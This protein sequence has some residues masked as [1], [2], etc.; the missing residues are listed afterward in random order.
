MK[1]NEF[2]SCEGYNPAEHM[3]PLEGGLY[4]STAER[5]RWFNTYRKENNLPGSID[6]GGYTVENTP[7]G[8]VW[9][10]EVSVTLGT[11]VYKGRFM[12]PVLNPNTGNLNEIALSTAYTKAIGRALAHAGFGNDE[13][14][15]ADGIDGDILADSP[16]KVTPAA[17][18][19]PVTVP[20][21]IP[22]PAPI[23]E[24]D[25]EGMTF[26]QAMAVVVSSRLNSS[27]GNLEGKTMGEVLAII[28]KCVDYIA[29]H[30]EKY[31]NMPQVVEAAKVLT[32]MTQ[33]A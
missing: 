15:L 23:P 13:I 4:L 14:D 21:P 29:K 26:E 12:K 9:I 7:A 33:A 28:P 17:Q 20:K 3:L 1:N 11:E 25:T 5:I 32:A 6:E 18:N 31:S 2:R 19:V 10:V 30:P 27:K 16:V 22:E 24:A 8:P